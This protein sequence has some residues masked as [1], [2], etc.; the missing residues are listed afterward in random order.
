MHSL[1]RSIIT[2]VNISIKQEVPMQEQII[3]MISEIKDDAQLANRLNEHSS[4]MED[5]DS[6][7]YS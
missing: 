4:I 6:T 2:K 3:A 7:R 5:G 1:E